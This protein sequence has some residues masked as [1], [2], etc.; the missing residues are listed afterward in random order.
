M[1][2]SPLRRFWNDRCDIFVRESAVDPQTGRTVFHERK[3]RADLPCR[4]SFRISFETV[5]A[6]RDVGEG[7]SSAGQAV[8]LF[9]APEIHVP[10]GSKIVVR[11]GGRELV[12]ARS[13]IPAVFDHHQ[14]LRIERFHRW[15]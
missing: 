7:A 3:L 2:T 12:F 5:S 13:G 11:R 4:L 1:V 6:V 8:K 9:L 10:A 14:E 15:I